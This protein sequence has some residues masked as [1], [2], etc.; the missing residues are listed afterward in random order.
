MSMDVNADIRKAME[1]AKKGYSKI[2]SSESSSYSI[3][4]KDGTIK[5]IEKELHNAE[6]FDSDYIDCVPIEVMKKILK[7]LKYDRN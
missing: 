1:D 6:C 4:Q 7:F 5:W 3:R 2:A